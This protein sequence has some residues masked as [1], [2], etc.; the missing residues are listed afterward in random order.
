MDDEP[1]LAS[2]IQDILLSF[3]YD[4]EIAHDGLKAIGRVK[5]KAFDIVLMDIRDQRRG[6]PAGD[7][8]DA[9]GGRGDNDDRLQRRGSDLRG[10]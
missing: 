3:G 1:E 6:S 7:Q 8:G 10:S 2:S 5:I 4:V 9:A